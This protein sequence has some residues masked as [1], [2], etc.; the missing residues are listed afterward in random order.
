[1][2]SP[3]RKECK[4]AIPKFL[5]SRRIEHCRKI[6]SL[7]RGLLKE[8]CQILFTTL[9]YSDDYLFCNLTQPSESKKPSSCTKEEQCGSVKS[10]SSP[11]SKSVQ[12]QSYSYVSQQPS[13]IQPRGMD[14]LNVGKFCSPNPRTTKFRWT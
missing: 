2:S 3:V 9:R 7:I 1:M 4:I 13:G 5:E 12:S 11:I 14:N 8:M 6:A 10:F